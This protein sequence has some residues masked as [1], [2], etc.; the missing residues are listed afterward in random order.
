[1]KRLIG[2]WLGSFALAIALAASCSIEHRS[3]AF[4]C[5]KQSDC[6]GGR[7]CSEGFCVLTNVPP[8]DGPRPEQDGDIEPPPDAPIPSECPPQCT[9]CNKESR[10][11]T[12]DCG[13]TDCTAQVVCPAG[14]SCDI[15][16][17]RQN[18]C[19]NGVNCLDAKSCTLDCSGDGACRNVACGPGR[20]N[21]TCSGNASCRSVSCSQ[22]CACDVECGQNAS[23]ETVICSSF[24]CETFDG[25]TSQTIGCDICP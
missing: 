17:N 9:S 19:R 22:S 25:C 16:C 24:A 4:A 8:S 20:C 23:C 1:M 6:S 7:V 10:E 13:S 14:W 3:D 21:V 11:C 18:S 12:I 5:E 15:Q 2:V